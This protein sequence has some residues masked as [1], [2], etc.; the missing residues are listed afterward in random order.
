MDDV[1]DPIYIRR[2]DPAP[3]VARIVLAR[4]ETR[5]AQSPTLLYQLDAAFADATADNSVKVIVLA[6]D[7]PDFSSGHDL[8][9]G[10][11][12][13]CAPVATLQA[14]LGAE[15]AE[16][17]YAF[18]C[19]AFLGLCKRW[20]DIPKPTIA[21]A[22]G[23]TIAGGLML[24]WPMDII[25]A[26]DDATFSDPVT[27]FGVNGVEYFTH[28]WEL[29]A[30]KAKEILYTGRALTAAEAREVGMVNHVVEPAALQEFTTQLATAIAARPQFGLRLAKESVNR[31]LD[32]QGQST[33]LDSAIALHN[34]GHANN[35]A[36]YGS[37]LDPAGAEVIRAAARTA[38]RT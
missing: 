4:P 33:A 29:G 12:L 15:G 13:P 27:A 17:H 38:V 14:G 22:Q 37:I 32:A 28:A 1:Q 23:R 2:E 26:A 21:Q 20:R 18:E 8:K 25:I 19:E 31:S 11:T 34:L 35:L 24:L 7:G 36:R 10:F 3:G 16:G 5:N 6:A 9:A 30:R